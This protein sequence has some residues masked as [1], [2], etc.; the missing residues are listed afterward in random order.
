MEPEILLAGPTARKGKR[1]GETEA[2][3]EANSNCLSREDLER[4]D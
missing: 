4:I 2:R 1:K 3:N